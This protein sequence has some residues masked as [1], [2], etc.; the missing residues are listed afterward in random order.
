MFVSMGLN[1]TPASA[2][3][4]PDGV[5][6]PVPIGG[7]CTCTTYIVQ[8]VVCLTGEGSSGQP[9]VTTC[10]ICPAPCQGPGC[11]IQPCWFRQTVSC[12]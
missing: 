9:H 2:D 1:A 10:V 12:S 8:N 5:C 6:G 11:Q 3:S 7:S 4:D